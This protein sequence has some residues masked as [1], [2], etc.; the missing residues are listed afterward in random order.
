M[1]EFDQELTIDAMIA[2]AQSDPDRLVRYRHW[3]VE[4]TIKASSCPDRLR[5]VQCRIER[6]IND[7]SLTPHNRNVKLQSMMLQSLHDMRDAIDGTVP[8]TNNVCIFKA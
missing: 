2:L 6:V 4:R 8:P 7:K 1:E 3:L 5:A